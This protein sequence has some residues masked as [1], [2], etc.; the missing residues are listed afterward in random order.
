MMDRDE[1][2]AAEFGGAPL[3]N[4]LRS[5][6]LVKS[7]SLL[8]SVIGQP[9]TGNTDYDRAAVKAHYRFLESDPASA[10]TPENILAPH[11]ARTIER[12]RSQAV[13]L[14]IQDGSRLRYDPRPACTDLSVIGRNQTPTQTRGMHVHTTLATTSAGLPLG[15]LRCSYRDTDG[16][17]LRP[18]AQ[19]WLDA[20]L[21]ICAAGGGQDSPHNS[22][23]QRHGPG[24]GQFCAL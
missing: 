15:V 11:R 12:M 1:W 13:V 19:R 7:A 16:G 3:G 4:R 21:D 10:V 23:D 18:K 6:R 9:I 20:Y 2:A 5:T 14:C 8:A 17:P 24:G 22:G